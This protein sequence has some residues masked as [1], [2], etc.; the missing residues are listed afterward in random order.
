MG[1]EYD[2]KILEFWNF[3]NDFHTMSGNTGVYLN[4]WNKDKVDDTLNSEYWNKVYSGYTK[5]E[6][7]ARNKKIVLDERWKSKLTDK[8][9][10]IIKN[11]TPAQSAYK[12]MMSLVKYKIGDKNA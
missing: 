5:Q 8:Q 9:K 1:I 4:I 10:T 2:P 7:E 12:R 6:L 3:S 11:H